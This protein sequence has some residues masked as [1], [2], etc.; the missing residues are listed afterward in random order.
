[1]ERKYKINPKNVRQ[2]YEERQKWQ[3]RKG[4]KKLGN[5]YLINKNQKGKDIQENIN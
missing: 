4:L 2:I 1:M 3:N 5:R